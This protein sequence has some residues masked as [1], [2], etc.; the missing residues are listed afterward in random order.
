MILFRRKIAHEMFNI[1]Q[2][3]HPQELL[4]LH[5][6]YNTLKVVPK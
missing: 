5:S 6:V 4:P 1:P 3:K 2:E